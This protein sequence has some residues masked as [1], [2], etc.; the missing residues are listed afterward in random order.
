MNDLPRPILYAEDDENDIYLMQ[1]AFQ[2]VGVTHPLE[3]VCDGRAALDRLAQ[4]LDDGA[5]PQLILLD[6]KLPR[7]SGLETL[8]RIRREPRLTTVPVVVLT[9][10]I[11][12]EDTKTARQLG[13]TAYLVKAPSFAE[14]TE[15]VARLRDAFLTGCG[16]EPGHLSGNRLPSV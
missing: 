1:R 9:S 13:A 6:L 15:T 7:L 8:E 2:K 11:Q 14:L 3:V 4:V 16:I 12:E 5:L 10:S